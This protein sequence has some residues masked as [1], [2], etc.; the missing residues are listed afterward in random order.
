MC[1]IKSSPVETTHNSKFNLVLVNLITKIKSSLDIIVDSIYY[2]SDSIVCLNWIRLEPHRLQVF[3]RN[4]VSDIQAQSD[5]SSWRYVPSSENPADLLSR[6]TSTRLLSS[7]RLWWHGPTW[8]R[9]PESH[10]P[11]QFDHI[12][13]DPPEVKDTNLNALHIT[14]HKR[15]IPFEKCSKLERLVRITAF[16]IRFINIRVRKLSVKGALSAQEMRQATIVLVSL[17][18]RES[19]PEEYH[20][21]STNKDISAQSRIELETLFAQ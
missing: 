13:I 17:A 11:T 21:F 15:I 12:P 18:Q 6:G 4:R 7:S 19:F 8:L 16:C 5:R 9:E 2:W 20:A 3:V 10:W 1:Q 14:T